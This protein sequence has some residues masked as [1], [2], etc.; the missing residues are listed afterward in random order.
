MA[1]QEER[2][3]NL[4]RFQRETIQAVQDSNVAIT[5]LK[6]VI[7]SQGQ[8]IKAMRT[9]IANI[10]TDMHSIAATLQEHTNILKAILDRLPPAPA[11]E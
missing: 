11:K 10:R 3:A 4:E 1:T 8:D 6:G 2:I 7:G 5:A 9:D